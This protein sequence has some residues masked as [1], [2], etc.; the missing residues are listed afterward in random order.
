MQGNATR[1]GE[2]ELDFDPGAEDD[3]R[4]SFIGRIRTPWSRENCPKNVRKA[5]ET[6]QGACIEIRPELVEGLEGL[7]VGQGLMLIYWMHQARRDLI[8]QTP[9]HVEGARGTFALR[10]PNRPN[11]VAMSA[12]TI[13]G[14][15]L[16]KGLIEI[17]AIDCFDGTPLVDL[18]TWLPTVD[19]PESAFLIYDGAKNHSLEE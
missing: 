1:P 18:K 9:R 16:E 10:S 8:K 5:R 7:Q 13:T 19:M 6:G 14:L 17:D 4:L 11:P 12:V 3:A 2:K 15:D